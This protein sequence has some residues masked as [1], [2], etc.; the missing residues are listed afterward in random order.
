MMWPS[1]PENNC[2]C[3]GE[4]RGNPFP[5][6]WNWKAEKCKVIVILSKQKINV[7]ARAVRPSQ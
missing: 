4:A 2:H 3:G 7:I 5:F 1:G 6:P